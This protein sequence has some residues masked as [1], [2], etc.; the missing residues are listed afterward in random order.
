MTSRAPG[1]HPRAALVATSVLVGVLVVLLLVAAATTDRAVPTGVN[2]PD[3]APDPIAGRCWPLPTEHLGFGYQVRDDDKQV[4]DADGERRR[5]L[6]LQYDRVDADEVS[7]RLDDL[8][9]AAGFVPTGPSA[10]TGGP[11][12]YSL[13]GYGTVRVR[14]TT[15]P[16]TVDETLVRGDLELDLPAAAA[17]DQ[18]EASGCPL[19]EER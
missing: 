12:V 14:V 6:R 7:A 17:R 4:R 2:R 19:Q 9:T 15:L 5:V 1:A 10:G 8:L 16:E 11:V 13:D 18:L 3:P